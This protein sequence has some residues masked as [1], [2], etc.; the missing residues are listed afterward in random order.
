MAHFRATVGGAR[1]GKMPSRIIGSRVKYSSIQ[2]Q[3]RVTK[4]RTI[5]IRERERP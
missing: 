4:E 5:S 1:G 2:G 3:W